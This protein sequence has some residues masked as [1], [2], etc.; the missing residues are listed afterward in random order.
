MSTRKIRVY[1]GHKLTKAS[2]EFLEKMRETK[3]F[4]KEAF[5]QFEFLE[6]LGTTQGTIADVYTQDITVN[7]ATCDLFIAYVDEESTGVGIELG[8]A[9]YQYKRPILLLAGKEKT[10][11]RLVLGIVPHHPDQALFFR[12]SEPAHIQATVMHAIEKFKLCV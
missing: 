2:E 5:P 6:F 4:L 10:I 1:F 9:L 8:A 3:A 7:V 11:S 12:V